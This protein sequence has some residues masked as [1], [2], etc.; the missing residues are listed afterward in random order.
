[1]K[2]FFE[3]RDR[4]ERELADVGVLKA[5]AVQRRYVGAQVANLRNLF[6]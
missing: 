2:E 5:F 3:P 1:M 4:V 6:V